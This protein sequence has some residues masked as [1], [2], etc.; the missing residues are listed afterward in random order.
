MSCRESKEHDSE[1]QGPVA[2]QRVNIYDRK[3]KN[4]ASQLAVDSSGNVYVSGTSTTTKYNSEGKKL[5]TVKNGPYITADEKGNLYTAG[6]SGG[7]Y[8]TIKYNSNG[9]LMWSARYNGPAGFEDC[10]SA[11]AVDGS[12]NVYVTGSTCE[13]EHSSPLCYRKH[14]STVKYDSAG[15]QLWVARYEHPGEVYGSP[16][17]VAVDRL[18]NVYVIGFFVGMTTYSDYTTIKYDGDGNQ[19]WVAS[20]NGPGSG[21]DYVKAMALD[22]SGDVYVTG[23]SPGKGT[24]TDYAT[25][26]YDSNGNQI[27]VAR[28]NGPANGDDEA[29]DMVVDTAGNVYVTG[30]SHGNHTQYKGGIDYATIK[31]DS[32][33]NQLW[34]ARYSS[35]GGK[36]IVV[37]SLGNSYV[38][39]G[40]GD[41]STLKY[42]TDGNQVWVARY[43]GELNYND[44][45]YAI[46]LD[47][48]G[49]VHVAGSTTTRICGAILD[50][51]Y[52]EDYVV[53]KYSQ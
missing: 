15:D 2:E 7:D 31:Y 35:S 41:I 20:Y 29:C 27:W 18:G 24:G 43:D 17:A 30:S 4:I 46:A 49:D 10:P 34:V 28:Y 23:Y 50:E 25:L 42:D 21:H 13:E 16:E 9:K 40:R 26:K 51:R 52:Y 53:I 5:W 6:C 11:I 44:E 3:E 1:L 48:Q 37:D 33:G 14:Y 38:T 8:I 12:G 32:E 47:A 36:A 39:G 45:A 19:L 22:E